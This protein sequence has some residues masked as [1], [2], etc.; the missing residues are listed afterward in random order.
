MQAGKKASK[1]IFARVS[2]FENKF[3]LLCSLKMLT[4]IVVAI[5]YFFRV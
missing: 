2:L 1:M 5:T 4:V 3:K